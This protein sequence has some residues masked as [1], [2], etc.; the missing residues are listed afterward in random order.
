VRDPLASSTA[1]RPVSGRRGRLQALA[2]AS[3]LGLAVAAASL[4][5]LPPLASAAATG[6]SAG[7]AASLPASA[8]A[9]GPNAGGVRAAAAVERADLAAPGGSR[10]SGTITGTAGPVADAVVTACPTSMAPQK[11]VPVECKGASTSAS[12]RYTISGLAPGSYV[13]RAAP[14][15]AAGTAAAAGYRGRSG[16]V[17]ARSA[18]APLAVAGDATGID[19]VLPAGLT[20]L[21]KATGTGGLPARDAFVE[22]CAADTAAGVACTGAYTTADGS[23]SIGGLGAGTYTVDVQ[24]RASSTLAGGYLGAAGLTPLRTG[25]RSVAAGTAGID[26]PLPQ[27]RRLTGTVSLEGAG[28]AGADQVLVQAC[29]DDSCVIGPSAWTLNDG[30]F[31]I[32]GLLPGTYTVS[33]SLPDAATHAS[34]FL[35]DGGYVPS[36]ATASR[37][38]IAGADVRGVGVVLP[39]AAATLSGTATG[40]GAGL[41]AGVVIACGAGGTCLWTR[42]AQDGS[43]VLPLPS[44]GPWTVGLRAPAALSAG[45]PGAYTA[46]IILPPDSPAVDGYLGAGGFTPAAAGA[47]AIVVGSPDR[48]KP[49]VVSRVPA[50]DSTKVSRSTAVVVRFSEP[51]TGVSSRSVTLRDAS[52]KKAAAAT[53]TYDAVTRKATLLP[54]ATLPAGR[55]LVVTLAATIADYSGNHLAP[56]TWTFMTKK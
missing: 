13:I 49:V 37:V 47:R 54:K 39:R 46:G 12:G 21:G 45:L 42:S 2:T 53:V 23:F 40:G 14:L 32:G 56:A 11:G 52:T 1:R 25:A 15:A 29:P 18:A 24:A 3:I 31:E 50:P 55:R 9:A 26:L 17:A 22:A 41:R 35:G 19:I 28:A 34:G 51:V 44:A 20:I 33:F 30:A 7:V 43:Y 27:A 48:T 5:T 4:T 16:Y 10:V 38:A 36:R 6:P 8:A